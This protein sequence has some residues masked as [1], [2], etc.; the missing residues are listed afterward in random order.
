MSDNVNHPIH[1]NTGKIE[2]IDYI[3]D[4]LTPEEYRGFIKGNIIK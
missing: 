3:E 4:M 2:S 1:Y